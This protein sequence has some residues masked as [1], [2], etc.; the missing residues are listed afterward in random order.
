MCITLNNIQHV[1][2]VL[3][4]IGESL[5]LKTYYKFLDEESTDNSLSA[6]TEALR[7]SILSSADEDIQE[8]KNSIVRRVHELVRETTM[9]MYI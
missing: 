7:L 1:K 4:D 2:G 6:R 9:Y 5:D 3:S 8:K